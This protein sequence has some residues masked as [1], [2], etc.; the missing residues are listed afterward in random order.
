MRPTTTRDVGGP[1]QRSWN[2]G[3]QSSATA[4]DDEYNSEDVGPG[5]FVEGDEDVDGGGLQVRHVFAFGCQHQS[6]SYVSICGPERDLE[7]AS[8]MVDGEF[9][10]GLCGMADV[11]ARE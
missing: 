3:G 6:Q 1:G 11:R 5:A 4:A 10:Y 9:A 8:T 2:E 7:N